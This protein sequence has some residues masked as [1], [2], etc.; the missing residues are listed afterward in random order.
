MSD[1]MRRRWRR[2]D[3]DDDDDDD[4]ED[5]DD[6]TTNEGLHHVLD[7]GLF[8]MDSKRICVEADGG[9]VIEQAKKGRLGKKEKEKTWDVEYYRGVALHQNLRDPLLPGS[10]GPS[11]K[12]LLMC[13]N[14]RLG[15]ARTA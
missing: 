9:R 3:D 14:R 8:C 11:E 10:I 2:D 1:C 4:D 12:G 5:G 13:I 7:L 6:E 15:M